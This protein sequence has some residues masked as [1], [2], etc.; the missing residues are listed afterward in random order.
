MTEVFR[1]L[2]GLTSPWTTLKDLSF[3]PPFSFLRPL[4]S[5]YDLSWQPPFCW[6]PYAFFRNLLK[7][8]RPVSLPILGSST[9][10]AAVLRL[11]F[12]VFAC[13]IPG[14]PN[15]TS[16][17]VPF[18]LCLFGFRP[19]PSFVQSCMPL[20]SPN[21]SAVSLSRFLFSRWLWLVPPVRPL[22]GSLPPVLRWLAVHPPVSSFPAPLSLFVRAS[23]LASYRRPRNWKKPLRFF[24]CAS[25][26]WW[27]VVY[28]RTSWLHIHRFMFH[29]LW[30]R[31]SSKCSG[32]SFLRGCDLSQ[33]HSQFFMNSTSTHFSNM[34]R[35]FH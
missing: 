16:S 29:L 13:G 35:F 2:Y 22:F 28:F 12:F 9:I 8:F 24:G 31:W 33:R 14:S 10:P 21:R 1:P 17:P 11:C 34:F 30:C 19:H 15:A 7:L 23:E 26:L 32:C 5:G 25:L 27:S 6:P 3:T 4:I 20:P 18:R